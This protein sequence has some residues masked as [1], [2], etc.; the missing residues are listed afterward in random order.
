MTTQTPPPA[1][2]ISCV[3]SSR[4]CVCRTVITV[5]LIY[6]PDDTPLV[7]VRD[8]GRRLFAL[9]GWRQVADGPLCNEC[10]EVRS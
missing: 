5:A 4:C 9:E 10:R 2:D 6:G 1:L 3:L 7:E 8:A